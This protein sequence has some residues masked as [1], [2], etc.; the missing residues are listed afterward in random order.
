MRSYGGSGSW[1][2]LRHAG[3]GWGQQQWLLTAAAVAAV[4]QRCVGLRR[5][6]ASAS[7]LLL[8]EQVSRTASLL[9]SV[10]G[11]C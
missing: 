2:Q 11:V 8:P 4:K 5:G 6:A 3:G 7:A 9:F 10:S 1:Q